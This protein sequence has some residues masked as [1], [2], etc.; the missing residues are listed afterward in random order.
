LD[1][2]RIKNT[3]FALANTLRSESK[4]YGREG[5]AGLNPQKMVCGAAWPLVGG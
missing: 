1:V 4:K 3:D 2:V 5:H